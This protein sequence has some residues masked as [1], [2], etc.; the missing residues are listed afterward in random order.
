MDDHMKLS[1]YGIHIHSSNKPY[2]IYITLS[3]ILLLWS[4]K[5]F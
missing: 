5:N 4:Q 1:K 2:F 3:L